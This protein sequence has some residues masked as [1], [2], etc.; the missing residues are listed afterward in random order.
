LAI[1]ETTTTATIPKRE[2]V[3][4]VSALLQYELAA[5][6]VG[7]LFGLFG[8]MADPQF[9]PT[10]RLVKLILGT[11]QNHVL[12]CLNSTPMTILKERMERGDRAAGIG[13]KEI[14]TVVI[15]KV[16]DDDASGGAGLTPFLTLASEDPFFFGRYLASESR[17]D[18]DTAL[19][20]IDF[21]PHSGLDGPKD[22]SAREIRK[23]LWGLES[24]R[25]F[26]DLKSSQDSAGLLRFLHL[27]SRAAAR[28]LI[29]LSR[30]HTE[31]REALHEALFS[32]VSEMIETLKE[33]ETDTGKTWI[34]GVDQRP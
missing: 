15:E 6:G 24:S 26:L 21:L 14:F 1:I 29:D 18:E 31:I 5:R 11:L 2:V 27:G 7:T 28:A 8:K 23:L 19:R 25:Y 22:G 9:L 3:Q 30:E 4:Q 12:Y 13:Y 16:L 10:E 33:W 20:A 34:P 32:D 17:F